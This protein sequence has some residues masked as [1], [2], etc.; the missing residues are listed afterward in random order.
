MHEARN[1]RFFAVNDQK[2]SIS[3]PACGRNIVH[4]ADPW[5]QNEYLFLRPAVRIGS[6]PGKKRSARAV[7]AYL[8]KNKTILNQ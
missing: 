1:K 8:L 7:K 4:G 6:S 3:K 2:R 5:N